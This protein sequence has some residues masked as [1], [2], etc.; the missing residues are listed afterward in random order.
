MVQFVN[1]R[2]LKN[3]LSEIIRRS[4]KGDIVVTSRGKPTA[5]LHAV[6][7]EDLEDYLLAHS[8]KFLNSL[9]TSYREY[10]KKGGVSVDKLIRQ[11]EQE[12]GRIRR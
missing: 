3:R 2:E 8:P 12:L 1:I 7:G 6:S 9:K 11:A 10:K 4:R 5:V